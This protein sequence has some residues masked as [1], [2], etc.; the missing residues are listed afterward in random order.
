[1]PPPLLPKRLGAVVLAVGL[2]ALVAYVGGVVLVINSADFEAESWLVDFTAFWGAARLALE[3]NAVAAFD[4]DALAAAQGARSLDGMHEMRWHYPPG[5]LAV[6]AP[7]GLLP[8]SVAWISFGLV[9]V[10]L[11]L[12]A[13]RPLARG[14]PGALSWVLAAPAVLLSLA[15]GSNGLLAG[16]CMTAAVAALG[17]GRQVRA[18]LLIALMTLKPGLGLLIPPVLLAGR[19]WIAIAAAILGTSVI[20]AASTALFGAD[21]WLHFFAELGRVSNSL[22]A[23]SHPYPRMIT[24]YGFARVTGLD[25]DAALGLQAA[26]LAVV[27]VAVGLL[28]TREQV[29]FELKGAAFL[30]GLTLATPYAFYYE[31]VFSLAAILFLLRSGMAWPTAAWVLFGLIWATPALGLGLSGLAP[32]ALIA[33]PLQSLGLALVF[34]VGLWPPPG[35]RGPG[36][37]P[38]WTRRAPTA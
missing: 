35:A 33:A 20:V 27:S 23:G 14:I 18:G 13:I 28:W 11:F 22:A 5:W 24:W 32:V 25:H 29:P 9:S 36:S 26:A 19:Q 34:W 1:M 37:S 10:G 21:Y 16:A 3:G 38:E 31:M 8:F 6:I 12:A 4:P 15:I 7:L 17:A 2:V 30:F